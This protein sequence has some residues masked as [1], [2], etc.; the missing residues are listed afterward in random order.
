MLILGLSGFFHDSAAAL[1]A[2]G[3]LIAA[4]HEERFSRIRHDPA[5][6]AQA[7]TW[8]LQQAGIDQS[9][10]DFIVWYEKPLRHFERLL[11][12]ATAFAPLGLRS[13]TAAMPPWLEE[14]LWMPSVIRRHFPDATNAALSFLEHHQSHAAS[15][16]FP[17]PFHE[18]AV[19]TVD[20]V[21][22]W[23]T[24]SWG[25]A[26]GNRI[27]LLREL[28]FPH[29]LGLLYSAFTGHLGFKVNSGEYKVMGLAPY[30]QPVHADV[31]RR[32]LL[33]RRSDG[34][35]RLRQEYFQYCHGLRMTNRRF[36][37]LFGI[38]PRTPE[39]PL[40]QCHMDLAASIQVVAEELLLDMARHVHQQTQLENLVMAG[41]VALNCVANS[42]LQQD[43][44][45][46]RVWVQ[47]AAGD[48]GA[49]LGAALFVWHQLLGQPRTPPTP[50]G[51]HA[52][53]TGPSF[54]APHIQSILLKYGV[55]HEQLTDEKMLTERVAQLLAQGKTVGWFQGAMEFGPRALGHRSILADARSN[56]IQTVLNLQVKFRESFR[57]F[58]PVVLRELVH[59]WFETEPDADLPYMLFTAKVQPDKLT[60]LSDPD[61]H[62]LL[63]SPD[64]LER[65][66]IPRS[67]IPAVTHVDASARIQTVD[68]NRHPRLH[69]LLT[70]FENLTG[71]PVL[72]NTSFNVRG[73]PIVCNPED[74]LACFHATGLDVLVL[75]D[76]L[77][78]DKQFTPPQRIRPPAKSLRQPNQR[79][80]RQFALLCLL[81]SI[82]AGTATLLQQRPTW[83]TLSF[84]AVAAFSIP[85]ILYPALAR[86]PFLFLMWAT[87]PLKW[88]TSRLLLVTIF[89]AFVCPIGLLLRIL[90]HDPLQRRDSNKNSF[91]QSPDRHASSPLR[92]W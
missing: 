77:I 60:P 29:S 85:A 55:R 33:D 23:A 78:V 40:L 30:G 48:A 52:S 13:F 21:G 92:P 79:M 61:R 90:R 65:V 73:E 15:A 36:T 53:L 3:H 63:H 74:A 11:E 6:P 34:S 50:D 7:A 1:V 16:F 26:Q 31:I 38:P 58:A 69:R 59:R 42:R 72:V 45:F 9:Q 88:L 5:F 89:T 14:K 76:F 18:A 19:L 62:T 91:W 27:E 54:K 39:S 12:T 80:L 25:R 66:R 17:S 75:E 43:G 24:A 10:L 70:D 32:H 46:R 4:A 71:C 84:T 20:G 81:F 87:T 86:P 51:C 28:R 56:S 64:L 68:R 35:F 57:P 67:L 22:E 2:D 82:A 44:P 83:V 47:P 8:C 37:R 41:G 49:A